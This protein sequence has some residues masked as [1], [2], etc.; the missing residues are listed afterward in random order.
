MRMSVGAELAPIGATFSDYRFQKKEHMKPQIL[1][2]YQQN[3][4]D[5]VQKLYKE[6]ARSVLMVLPTGGG[7]TTIFCHA[8]AKRLQASG[9]RSLLLVHRREL[10][11]Q[12][13]ARL[14][15]FGV[16]YGFIMQ[17]EEA[18][19]YAPVQIAT[20]QSLVRRTQLPDADLIVC[21]EAHLSAAESW[22]S[23][24]AQYPNAKILGVT[25]T[26]WR[27]GGA[28]LASMYDASVVVAR[29]AE[30]LEQGFLS[31]YQGFTFLA[32][33]LSGVR[34]VGDDYNMQQTGAAMSQPQIV[35]NVV[36]QWKAHASH[37][38]TVVFA[39]TIEH[40][41][42]LTAEFRAAGVRAEHIDGG[43]RLDQRR[44]ILERVENGTTQV[45]CN[46][47]IAVE[48]LD[49]PRLKCCVLARPTMSLSRH[50]QMMGRVRRPWNGL[51][52]RIHDHAFNI[53][54][55]GLPD[56]HR[57]YEL[58]AK[59][60]ENTSD[61]PAL[62]TCPKCF[63][64]YDNGDKCLN[65]AAPRP[66]VERAE[67]R[68]I[69]DAEKVEFSS[70][71][72]PRPENLP[73]VEISW[74]KVGRDV[75]G[76]YDG[77]TVEKNETYTRNR[78]KLTGAKRVYSLPGT[79]RLDQMMKSV[80]VGRQIRVTYTGNRELNDGRQMKEFKVEVDD[81]EEHPKCIKCGKEFKRNRTGPK[82]S[83]CSKR[84][85]R[86]KNL[87]GSNRDSEHREARWRELEEFYRENGR[88][89]NDKN[90][91]EKHLA[92]IETTFRRLELDRLHKLR[93][94]HN[95]VIKTGQ[96]YVDS[97]WEQVETFIDEH[98]RLP[99]N[100]IQNGKLINF[101]K[102]RR[103]HEP[104][105]VEALW[106]RMKVISP[107]ERQKMKF[108]RL[109]RFYRTHKRPPSGVSLEESEKQ[110]YRF[111]QWQKTKGNSIN[112]LRRKC[113]ISDNQL[114]E[115]KWEALEAHYKATKAR[116]THEHEMFSFEG[117]AFK[118]FKK[119]VLKLRKKHGVLTLQ[120]KVRSRLTELEKWYQTHRCAPTT[121]SN[122]SLFEFVRGQV[123]RRNGTL[124]KDILALQ[125]KYGIATASRE[126]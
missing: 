81:S 55:H 64:I 21:D 12:A 5:Q 53:K 107:D 80:A 78:Y 37:L 90:E 52:A 23:I 57:S 77:V 25:A 28:P 96:A 16:E 11:E 114:H 62:W 33:D 103:K 104:Q 84:C 102:R 35:A 46:V 112:R 69:D 73:T 98:G 19:P 17:G 9:R 27:L 50:I 58:H 106:Q 88:I 18:T 108:T 68:T 29:P 15:E 59:N 30:L 34:K 125:A 109:E 10:A 124:K 42:L 123:K 76:R 56:A 26:P 105:R 122:M 71:D 6:G 8:I 75:E 72:V 22:K 86:K 111:E 39:V 67:L 95:I 100:N 87:K 45:V 85:R 61:L 36:E 24:L 65:C 54:R 31:P 97:M 41:Q 121:N 44:A 47:G 118:H 91:S 70:D 38:S 110:L 2:P 101:L 43:M 120:D 40:S 14:R 3:G 79:K 115:L 89:P 117:Y 126:K 82:P 113:N 116:T 7:K 49:I 4:I 83:F 93:E 48:G 119:R 94:T 92:N 32:P 13:S 60:D 63:A 20:V 66:I 74:T 51:T 1:R 99:G